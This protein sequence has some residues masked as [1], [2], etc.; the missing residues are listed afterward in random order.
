MIALLNNMGIAGF[1]ASIVIIVADMLV[2]LPFFKIHE[3]Q[4]NLAEAA[5]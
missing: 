1:V 4:R 5:A 2:W 3:K